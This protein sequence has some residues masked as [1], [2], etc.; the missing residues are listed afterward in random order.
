MENRY[1]KEEELYVAVTATAASESSAP[2]IA[3]MFHM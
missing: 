2:I 3:Y 1:T